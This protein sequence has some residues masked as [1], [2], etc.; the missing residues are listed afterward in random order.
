MSSSEKRPAFSSGTL[1]GDR[2]RILSTLGRGGFGVVYVAEQLA[3]ERRVALKLLSGHLSDASAEQ[4]LQ[5]ARI[6]ARLSSEHIVQVFDAGIDSETSLVFVAMELLTGTNLA[7]LVRKEGPRSASEVTEYVRQVALGLDK[8]HALVTSDGRVTSIV[9]RDLKPANLFLTRRED[10]AAW[11]KILD[12]GAAKVLSSD[13]HVSGVMRGTPEYMAYE[14]ISGG[15]VTK[16]TDIW[17]L[18]LIAF[19]LSTGRSY[20]LGAQGESGQAQ[21]FGEILSLPIV[22]PSVRAKELG[23]STL[24]PAFDDWFLRCV[25]RDPAQRYAS[26]G[27][28]ASALGRALGVPLGP[29]SAPRASAEASELVLTSSPSTPSP[30]TPNL[31]VSASTA[32][33]IRAPRSRITAAIGMLLL[34]AVA[35]AL[36]WPR[37]RPDAARK[38]DNR[39]PNSR[40]TASASAEIAISKPDAAPSPKLGSPSVAVSAPPSASSISATKR[41]SARPLHAAEAKGLADSAASAEP[42]RPPSNEHL[43]DLR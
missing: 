5:E 39:A 37:S 7:E 11:I 6:A 43:Y 4:L 30:V 20:W 13:T 28:A 25:N 31:A 23:V 42:P 18:G 24:E 9:H 33:S 41:P 34:V 29:V 10:G 1:I 36:L 22:P 40:V 21:I 17:A 27:E 16:A 12:F 2:Y 8:T 35:I 38:S 3:T 19:F 26:A 14:Q 32:R 15:A